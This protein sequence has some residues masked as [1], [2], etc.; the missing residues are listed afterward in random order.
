MEWLQDWALVIGAGITLLAVLV[1]LGIGIASILHTQSMQKRERKERLLDKIVEW[2]TDIQKASLEVDIPASTSKEQMI[3]RE[4]NTLLRYVSTFV[5]NSYIKAI[6]N[7]AFK[8]ELKQDV[9]NM[10]NAF[11]AFL[12]LKGKSFGMK[13]PRGAFR[14][15]SIK[16]IEEVEKRLQEKALQE[17]LDEYAEEKSKCA[18]ILLTKVGNI[19]ANL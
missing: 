17:L 6:V 18:N 10:T 12:F 4:A 15:K 8:D 11:T 9:E 7:E 13:N 2:V 1:A 19:I 3:A 14:G 16:I 5:R